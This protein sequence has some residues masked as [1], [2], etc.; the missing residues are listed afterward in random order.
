LEGCGQGRWWRVS[1]V[2]R[3][4]LPVWLSVRCAPARNCFCHISVGLPGPAFYMID[5]LPACRVMGEYNFVAPASW[6]GYRELTE[7]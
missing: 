5:C 1:W 3:R 7:K 2:G 4:A 6:Q